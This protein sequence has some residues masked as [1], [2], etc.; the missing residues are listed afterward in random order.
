MCTHTLLGSYCHSNPDPSLTS[1]HHTW[2]RHTTR[3]VKCYSNA[4]CICK[5][6]GH[7]SNPSKTDLHFTQYLY[8]IEFPVHS[9]MLPSNLY[10]KPWFV[11]HLATVKCL[12][13]ALRIFWQNFD[14]TWFPFRSIA[15]QPVLHLTLLWAI[16]LVHSKL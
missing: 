16:F 8:W 12:S 10:T 3:A 2:I 7:Y 4:P 1:L 6:S 5:L 13:H 11:T 14:K 9:K 15:I